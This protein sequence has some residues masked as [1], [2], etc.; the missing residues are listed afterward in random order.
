MPIKHETPTLHSAALGLSL[1]SLYRL[2]SSYRL[3]N[4]GPV[5]RLR[6]LCLKGATGGDLRIHAQPDEFECCP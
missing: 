3:V 2:R 6:A 1:S 5:P 4:G